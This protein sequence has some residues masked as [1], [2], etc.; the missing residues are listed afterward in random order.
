MSCLEEG[1]TTVVTNTG[2]G[3]C[4]LRQAT[5]KCCSLHQD[6]RSKFFVVKQMVITTSEDHGEGTAAQSQESFDTL[7]V[8]TSLPPSTQ[9]GQKSE[10]HPRHHRSLRR[11][12]RPR[13]ASRPR[14]RRPHHPHPL[15][16][17]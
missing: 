9:K 16:S 8:S 14:S 1:L 15:R 11:N 13:H 7:M 4:A 5:D 17:L 3:S 12:L 2:F 10:S 6:S